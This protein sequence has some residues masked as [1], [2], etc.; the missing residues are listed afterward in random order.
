M[1]GMFQ[2]QQVW[3]KYSERRGNEMKTKG[4]VNGWRK[5]GLCRVRIQSSRF[6]FGVRWG[7]TEE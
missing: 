1:I 5:I 7:A 4:Q 6:G 3:M 2:K